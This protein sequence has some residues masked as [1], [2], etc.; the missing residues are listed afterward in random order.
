MKTELVVNFFKI[1]GKRTYTFWTHD[2]QEGAHGTHS[3]GLKRELKKRISNIDG[4]FRLVATTHAGSSGE[5]LGTFKGG[6][7]YNQC[8]KA[9]TSFEK[10]NKE[11]V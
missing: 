9:L 8:L 7:S 4:E 2:S 3:T 5:P 11:K 6:T 1:K 10:Q